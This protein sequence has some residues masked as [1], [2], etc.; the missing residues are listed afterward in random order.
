MLLPLPLPSSPHKSQQTGREDP[1]TVLLLGAPILQS[2]NKAAW[3]A[4]SEHSTLWLLERFTP[5]RT[6]LS[7]MFVS[8]YHNHSSVTVQYTCDLDGPDRSRWPILLDPRSQSGPALPSNQMWSHQG[9]AEAST[10][11]HLMNWK[12]HRVIITWLQSSFIQHY[13][14]AARVPEHKAAWSKGEFLILRTF[15]W[16]QFC[17]LPLL[18]HKHGGRFLLNFQKASN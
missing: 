15:L 7:I 10:S 4:D 9:S 5:F 11:K 16:K 1:A 6:V 2:T 8:P 14:W 18:S 13:L 17:S 12:P 3:P